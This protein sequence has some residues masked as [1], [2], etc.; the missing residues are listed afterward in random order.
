MADKPI[1]AESTDDDGVRTALAN[2]GL[3]TLVADRQDGQRRETTIRQFGALLDNFHQQPLSSESRQLAGALSRSLLQGDLKAVET[4][5]AQN[6]DKP[7]FSAVVSEVGGKLRGHDLTVE[8]SLEH[9]K[10]AIYRTGLTGLM[11][12]REAILVDGGQPSVTSSVKLMDRDQLKDSS[13]PA[14]AVLGEFSRDVLKSVQ[15]RTEAA[16]SA[17]LMLEQSAALQ[18]KSDRDLPVVNRL[19]KDILTGNWQDI[20]KALQD[21]RR[22]PADLRRITGKLND[23]MKTA[24]VTTEWTSDGLKVAIPQ[25]LTNGVQVTMSQEKGTVPAASELNSTQ[26]NQ[27]G[28]HSLVFK[29]GPYAYEPLIPMQAQ[30]GINELSRR[31]IANVHSRLA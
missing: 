8:W 21:E 1:P 11:N 27:K 23:V 20:Q 14:A 3:V 4:F 18:L 19:A 31:A 10:L 22:T 17:G 29:T 15:E 16:G 12:E 5:V 2:D 7:G 25:G 24:G 13:R 28:V 6:R 30:D 9:R 26:G